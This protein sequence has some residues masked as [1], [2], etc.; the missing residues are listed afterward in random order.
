MVT[1]PAPSSRVHVTNKFRIT[2]D[3]PATSGTFVVVITII[4]FLLSWIVPALV[5]WLRPDGKGFKW[6]RPLA[7]INNMAFGVF[8]AL[9][10]VMALMGA[11]FEPLPALNTLIWPCYDG[12]PHMLPSSS[13]LPSTD[14]LSMVFYAFYLSKIYEFLDIILVSCMGSSISTYFR[15]HHCT[16]L[17]IGYASLMGNMGSQLPVLLLNTLHHSLMYP[18]IAGVRVFAPFMP[19]TGSAQLIIGVGVCLRALASRWPSESDDEPDIPCGSSLWAELFCLFM[20]TIYLALWYIEEVRPATT[21][22]IVTLPSAV[23]STSP[24]GTAKIKST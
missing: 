16:T 9:L 6:A 5:K 13:S 23:E 18:L 14:V 19:I 20:Y 3:T 12:T 24:D 7:K 4:F 17:A 22:P 10:F 11:R 1:T 15:V 8:S 21:K 2:S